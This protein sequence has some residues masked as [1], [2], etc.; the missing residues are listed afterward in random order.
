MAR[1]KTIQK[2]VESLES[3][4]KK[5][6]RVLE[7]DVTRLTAK[8]GKRDSVIKK[9]KERMKAKQRKGIQKKVRETKKKIRK[10]VP[11]IG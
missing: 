10:L 5:R 2:K 6:V 4:L 3:Q 8:L 1:A 11:K 9:L 7:R